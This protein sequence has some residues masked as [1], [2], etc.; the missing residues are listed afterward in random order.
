MSFPRMTIWTS[1]GLQGPPWH[2][3]AKCLS[4]DPGLFFP[5]KG[6]NAYGEA[7]NAKD[8]CNGAMGPRDRPCPVREE[9]LE[10]ALINNEGFG[11][12]GGMSERE[13]RR[14]RRERRLNASPPEGPKKRATA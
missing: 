4:S 5:D 14:L 6:G 3:H 8:V 12:W 10:W 1:L 11:V 7:Q 9:C 13:R 2:D